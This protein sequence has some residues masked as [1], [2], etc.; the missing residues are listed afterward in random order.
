MKKSKKQIIT[1]SL[2]AKGF[3]VESIEFKP[4]SKAMEMCG[5]GGGWEIY[6]SD[7]T[8]AKGISY[9]P[10][11]GYNSE[12]V[13]KKIDGLV[14]RIDLCPACGC[15]ISSGEE[16]MQFCENCRTDFSEMV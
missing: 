6:I 9:N 7:N 1:E 12:E 8:P 15:G 14:K 13:L 5:D 3:E 16:N 10:I 2:E 11:V 4:V